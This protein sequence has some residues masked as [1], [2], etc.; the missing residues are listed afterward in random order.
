MWG[1]PGSYAPIVL[2]TAGDEADCRF[3]GRRQEVGGRLGKE[4]WECLIVFQ[5]PTLGE[6]WLADWLCSM[7]N[8]SIWPVGM[9]EQQR[10]GRGDVA[11]RAWQ[12]WRQR[13]R[14]EDFRMFLAIPC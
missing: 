14:K 3:L 1:H 4:A 2:R 7:G 6:G 5:S 8:L 12:G 11:G 9:L 10:Q 13:K